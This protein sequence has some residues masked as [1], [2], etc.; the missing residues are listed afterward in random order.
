M[1]KRTPRLLSAAGLGL[2][3]LLAVVARA[4]ET[5]IIRNPAEPPGGTRTVELAERW[6]IGADDEDVLLGVVADVLTDRAGNL[7]LL[8]RQLCEIQILSPEGE[9][10]RTVGREGDGPGEFRRPRGLMFNTD[11]TLCV[12]RRM[13]GE[14]VLLTRDGESAGTIPPALPEGEAATM[15]ALQNGALRDGHLV[16]CGDQM[17]RQAGGRGGGGRGAP[18][19]RKMFLRSYTPA[20]EP[21][22]T[23]LEK[24]RTFDP[25]R[26][27]FVEAEE[28]FVQQGGWALGTGG[29]IYTAEDRDLYR[30]KVYSADGV[31]QRTIEREYE[32]YERTA[33]EKQS[34]ADGAV[35]MRRGRRIEVESVVAD[36]DPCI[37]RLD[38]D[39]TGDLWVQHGH[40]TKGLPSGVILSLDR[41]DE[42]G[43]YL[44]RVDFACP[45]NP[46][47]DRLIR[48]GEGRYVL[49]SGLAEAIES[50]R[51]VSR[52]EQ[53]EAE[54]APLEVLYLEQ[55]R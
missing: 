37:L 44:E 41:F 24:E 11:S 22:H 12:V 46:D 39:E 6:R 18:G 43:N 21:V 50:F 45:G 7:Y 25:Q 1:R 15:L 16:L 55:I 52:E 17:V 48:L 27:R 38:V 10:I 51:A 36:H 2:V 32:P 23:L 35:M 8:D 49:I 26:R 14:L 33:A 54:E 5:P 47:S 53:I 20:G 29:A 40:S 13:P 4:Q 19:S 31:L 28:Y 9:Y 34:V 3:A 30:I 42:S